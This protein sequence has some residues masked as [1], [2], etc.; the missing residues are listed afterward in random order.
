[1]YTAT[2]AL[3]L[4]S[5][6]ATASAQEEMVFTEFQ[7]ANATNSGGWLEVCNAG[8]ATVD[9]TN[10]NLEVYDVDED[11]TWAFNMPTS[12]GFSLVFAPNECFVYRTTSTPISP[13]TLARELDISASVPYIP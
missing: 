2:L 3:G 9:L 10:S 6:A 13:D 12:V 1:L 7:V 8:T 11:V 4:L 5:L